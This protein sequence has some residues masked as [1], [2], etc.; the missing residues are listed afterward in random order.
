MLE[1][2][3]GDGPKTRIE[4]FNDVDKFLEGGSDEVLP[5]VG[6]K[7][8]SD[9]VRMELLPFEA[10]YEIAKVLTFGAE[11]YDDDNWRQV[12]GWKKRYSGALLR[13]YTDYSIG[14]NIDGE[15]GLHHLA[16]LCCCGLFLLAKELEE[17]EENG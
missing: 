17:E 2:V 7:F 11:K 10:L 15:S 13:H 16:H 6:R 4:T 9:K 8:D 1:V 3:K 12:Q 5:P 14:K